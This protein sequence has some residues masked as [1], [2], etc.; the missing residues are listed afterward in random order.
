VKLYAVWGDTNGGDTT[1]ESSIALAQACFP[2]EGLT[3]DNGHGS[4][5]VLYI[6]FAGSEADTNASVDWKA[7]NFNEFEASL[8]TIGDA[9]VA[10]I[11]SSGGS[12]PTTS[13]SGSTPTCSWEGHCAGASCS[14][15]DDCSDVLVCVNGKC[16]SG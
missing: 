5:D 6:A 13:S 1:G 16:A 8:Q 7:S 12:T 2:N 4:N 3:G 10:K 14:T 15:D 9:L 11:G